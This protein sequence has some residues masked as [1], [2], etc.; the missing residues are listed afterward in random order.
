MEYER[1]FHLAPAVVRARTDDVALFQVVL[2]RV[3][4]PQL[5]G[6]WIEGDAVWVAQ[7]V[8][9]DLVRAIPAHEGIVRRDPVAAVR[10]VRAVRIDA[11][12]LAQDIQRGQAL[13][14]PT[15]DMSGPLV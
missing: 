10:G 1:P 6:H 14:V 8:R 3:S 13:R 4:R 12:D 9:P 11:Q 15:L 2:P 5:S 7:S